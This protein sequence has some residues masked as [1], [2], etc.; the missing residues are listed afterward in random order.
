MHS[1][2]RYPDT[3]QKAYICDLWSQREAAAAAAGQVRYFRFRRYGAKSYRMQAVTHAEYWTQKASYP[4]RLKDAT[5]NRI[6]GYYDDS[7]GG[8]WIDC[9]QPE[10]SCTYCADTY[11]YSYW[12][13]TEWAA[14]GGVQPTASDLATFPWWDVEDPRAVPKSEK[15]CYWSPF[16]KPRSIAELS[17]LVVQAPSTTL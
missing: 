6:S 14:Q 9:D 15:T 12:S 10:P 3:A 1:R 11:F 4:G 2:I 16:E 17:A 7:A 13:T 5:S 8:K